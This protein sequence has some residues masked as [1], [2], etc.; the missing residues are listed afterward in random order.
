M[1]IID[2]LGKKRNIKNLKLK[3]HTIP[4]KETGEEKSIMCVEFIIIGKN[5]EWPN[6]MTL[7]EFSEKNPEV[8]IG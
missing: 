1:K 2:S 6:Y 3:T 4:D 7:E 8:S 5:N